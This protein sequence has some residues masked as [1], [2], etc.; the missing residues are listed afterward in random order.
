MLEDLNMHSKKILMA[1]GIEPEMQRFLQESD[2]EEKLRQETNALVN[3]F[4]F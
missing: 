3:D 4:G 1:G 2:E